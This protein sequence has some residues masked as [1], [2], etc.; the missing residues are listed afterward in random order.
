MG[1][2]FVPTE[3]YGQKSFWTHLRVLLR[4]ETQVE[5]RFSP[6]GDNANLDTR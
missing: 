5:A 4:D 1:A 3:P 6:L 2:R